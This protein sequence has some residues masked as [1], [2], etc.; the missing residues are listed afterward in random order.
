MARL[1]ALFCALVL[2]APSLAHAEGLTALPAIQ[3]AMVTRF[4][5]ELQTGAATKAYADLVT[6]EISQKKPQEMQ[7]LVQQT[8]SAMSIYGKINGWEF[9]SA[10]ALSPSYIQAYYLVRMPTAPIFFKFDF[11]KTDTKWTVIRVFFMDDYSKLP[12]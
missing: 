10:K 8:N 12:E 5:K 4:F 1:I 9:M 11:Y 3:E 2:I 7:Y 6:E